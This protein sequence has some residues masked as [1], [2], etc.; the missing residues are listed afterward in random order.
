VNVRSDDL[1]AP[2]PPSSKNKSPQRLSNQFHTK[3]KEKKKIFSDINSKVIVLLISYDKRC[4]KHM[5]DYFL[6]LECSLRNVIKKNL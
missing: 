2:R 1:I 3:K 5:V 6:S 4:M